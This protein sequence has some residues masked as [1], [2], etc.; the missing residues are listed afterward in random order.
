MIAGGQPSNSEDFT[1]QIPKSLVNANY[2]GCPN[3]V[4]A[5]QTPSPGNVLDIN[6]QVLASNV[7]GVTESVV[8]NTFTSTINGATARPDKRSATPRSSPA[9]GGLGAPPDFSQVDSAGPRMRGGSYQRRTLRQQEARPNSWPC[10]EGHGGFASKCWAARD[11]WF[12]RVA[13][14]R[15]YP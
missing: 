11:S 1:T 3:G 5:L 13:S 12:T 15:C 2:Q 4:C 8:P 7:C 10:C 9:S 14:I 6:A